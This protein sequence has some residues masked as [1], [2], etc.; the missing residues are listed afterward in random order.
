MNP[1]DDAYIIRKVW[2]L[3]NKLLDVVDKN[4]KVNILVKI[5]HSSWGN[6]QGIFYPIE[7]HITS[8]L[9]GGII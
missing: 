9:R 1:F 4:I 3:E 8:C 6:L 2:G 5:D 7:I